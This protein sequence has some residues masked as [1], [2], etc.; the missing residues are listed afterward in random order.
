MLSGSFK[1][2]KIK[3]LALLK[4]LMMKRSRSDSEGGGR[5]ELKVEVPV[6]HNIS[7]C[8][9][10]ARSPPSLS[11]PQTSLSLAS[12]DGR[13]AAPDPAWGSNAV[14]TQRDS[15]SDSASSRETWPTVS[16]VCCIWEKNLSCENRRL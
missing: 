1:K 5:P 4:P 13:A 8:Q 10:R 2:N 3:G 11:H 9:P 12:S 14:T 7:S 6:R 16:R 15:R